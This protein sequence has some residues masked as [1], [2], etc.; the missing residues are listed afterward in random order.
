M[1]RVAIIFCAALF[2]ALPNISHAQY[3]DNDRQNSKEYHDEDSQPLAL[4][5]YFL[6]P[7][8]YAVEWLFSR[9][10]HYIAN[11]SPVAP[12][13]RPVG[14]NDA[15]P[16]PPVPIIPD[17]TLNSTSASA[18]QEWTPSRRPANSAPAYQ[19]ASPATQPDPAQSGSTSSSQPA[20]H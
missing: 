19:G 14:G 9:P 17:N 15:T 12:V 20:L 3:N 13:F 11:D 10:L 7:V 8:G 16:P 18:P 6:Y 5:S 2:L 4:V 1:R